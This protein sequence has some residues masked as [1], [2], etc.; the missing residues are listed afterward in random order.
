MV[1]NS[2]NLRQ[3]FTSVSSGKT[4]LTP[5]GQKCSQGLECLRY[6]KGPFITNTI[7]I[8]KTTFEEDWQNLNWVIGFLM[9]LIHR[10]VN[11][12]SPDDLKQKP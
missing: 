12:K 9:S 10:N 3:Q 2:F 4:S 6:Q 1:Q 8:N 11:I 7:F 5:V